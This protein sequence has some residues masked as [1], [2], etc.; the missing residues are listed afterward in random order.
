M[1]RFVYANDL[2]QFPRLADSM[3]RDRKGQFHDRL[4]WD[5]SVDA[6]GH[7][8]D[9]YDALNPLYCIHELEDGTHGG[10]GRLMPTLGRTMYGEHFTHL[11]DG[12]SIASPLVWESTRFCVS[13]RLHG[14]RAQAAKISTALMLAG[15]EIG[16]RYGIANYLAVFDKPMA[17]I[18]RATG[19]APEII[20]EEGT[21]RDA[22]CLGLWEVTPEARA[23]IVARLGA[24]PEFSEAPRAVAA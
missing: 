24:E 9:Q 19:W 1:I 11:S 16:L 20:G 3:F 22:L 2:H 4:A 12:V 5:I 10:S 15:C 13:P 18:Y 21:G 17:R 14:S 7:E 6:N 8:R 23:A